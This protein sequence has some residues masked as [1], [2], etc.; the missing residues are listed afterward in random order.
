MSQK[1]MITG[2]GPDQPG[3]VAGLTHVLY[4]H[5]CNIEDSSM[6]ILAREFSWLLLVN[7]PDGLNLEGL[8]QDM[9]TLAKSLGLSLFVKPIEPHETLTPDA[10]G[11]EAVMISVAGQDKTGITYRVSEVLS[12]FQVNITDL[13]AHTIEGE[14]GPVYIMMIE[15][16]LGPSVQRDALEKSLAGLAQELSLDIQM[17]PL[18]ALTF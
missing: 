13:N 3:I 18:E 2:V 9:D 17:K 14:D 7:A 12:E 5:Q 4:R 1:V 11:H 8:R 6:T 16:T 15:A 10:A